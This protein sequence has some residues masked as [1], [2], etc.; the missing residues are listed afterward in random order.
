MLDNDGWWDSDRELDAAWM[1]EMF[2]SKAVRVL[3]GDCR[4]NQPELFSVTKYE[5]EPEWFVRH[6]GSAKSTSYGTRWHQVAV[7][8]AFPTLEEALAYAKVTQRLNSAAA[9]DT[10]R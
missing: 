2:T 8:A 6:W 3:V 4:C 7:L 5:D 10:E 9:P 1:R